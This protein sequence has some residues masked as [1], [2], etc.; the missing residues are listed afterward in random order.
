M[1]DVSAM[2]DNTLI[3]TDGDSRL[4]MTYQILLQ[5][6]SAVNPQSIELF[7]FPLTYTGTEI[8][9][10]AVMTGQIKGFVYD[11]TYHNQL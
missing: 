11:K 8:M 2:S 7:P 6:S 9:K 4:L 3:V 10:L 5:G 1:M